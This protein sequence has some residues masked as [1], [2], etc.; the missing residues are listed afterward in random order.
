[1]HIASVYIP[2]SH[3]GSLGGLPYSGNPRMQPLIAL[4]REFESR[5]GDILSLYAKIESYNSLLLTAPSVGKHNS[6]KV[7]ERRKS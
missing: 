1:M 7:D 5:R 6:T 3:A 2:N 4:V